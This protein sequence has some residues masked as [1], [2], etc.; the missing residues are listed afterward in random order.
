[1][2]PLQICIGPIIRIG[3]ESW[4]LP[5]AGFLKF[6]LANKWRR[7]NL[8]KNLWAKHQRLNLD[9]IIV[10]SGKVTQTQG[11][12]L[13]ENIFSCQ[14]FSCPYH[15]VF[16]NLCISPDLPHH[17]SLS[18]FLYTSTIPKKLDGVGAVDNRPSSGQQHN[19]I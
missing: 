11:S 4:C 12:R 6:D 9:L 15:D 2:Q 7:N 18:S 16:T 1:M 8:L 5:Y 3:W 19:F 17:P 13:Q 14:S 10:V